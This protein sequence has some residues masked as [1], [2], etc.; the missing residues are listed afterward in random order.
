MANN[1]KLTIVD[2]YLDAQTKTIN[3]AVGK[4][5][6]DGKSVVSID[7]AL[8]RIQKII[9]KTVA[10][11]KVDYVAILD[12]NDKVAAHSD[13]NEIGKD[14]RNETDNFWGLTM[15]K[16]TSTDDDFF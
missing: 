7:I 1:G 8:D 11:G 14:Y 6:A 5:L 15:S 9:E 4:R 13:K 12:S 2:P 16:A 3:M 10:S